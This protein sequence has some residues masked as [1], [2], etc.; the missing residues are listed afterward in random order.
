[1]SIIYLTYTYVYLE[2]HGLYKLKT[3]HIIDVTEVLVLLI[4]Q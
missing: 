1:M 3:V 4:L 2:E